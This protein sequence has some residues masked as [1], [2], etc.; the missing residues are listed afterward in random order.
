MIKNKIKKSSEIIINNDINKEE[1]KMNAKK[2]TKKITITPPKKIEK[3]KV[4][5]DFEEEDDLLDDIDVN[6]EDDIDV[7]TN[8]PEEDNFDEVEVD[9]DEDDDG[10]DDPDEPEEEQDVKPVKKSSKKKIAEPEPEDDEED[11]EDEDE[12]V[13]DEVPPAVELL[14]TVKDKKFGPERGRRLFDKKFKKSVTVETKSAN[15]DENLNSIISKLEENGLDY[16]FDGVKFITEKKKLASMILQSIEESVLDCLYNKKTSFAFLNGRIDIT[17]ID[18]KFYPKFGKMMK[19]DV[20]KA[21]HDRISLVNCEYNRTVGAIYNVD[22]TSEL[23]VPCEGNDKAVVVSEDCLLYKKGD[24][25]NTVSGKSSDGEK[26]K[27]TKK[28]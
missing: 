6:G 19:T 20:Y 13:E 25:L 4:E 5:E 27:V 9:M 18:G 28:K 1:N 22:G 8:E 12:D 26:K 23:T 7:D 3:K 14:K 11:E 2:I 15:R 21:P 10:E 17:H 24:K 16:I